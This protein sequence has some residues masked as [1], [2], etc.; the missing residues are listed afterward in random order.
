MKI[1]A[2]Y[3]TE[4]K[5]QSLAELDIVRITKQEVTDKEPFLVYC[6]GLIFN[7]SFAEKNPEEPDTLIRFDYFYYAKSEKITVSTFNNFSI[8][9]HDFSGIP[10]F[11]EITKKI[12]E[13]DF[14]K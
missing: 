1:S 6:N 8:E 4:I 9:V 3:F 2:N 5:I 14:G 12:L 10:L 11:E 13:K 7:Y